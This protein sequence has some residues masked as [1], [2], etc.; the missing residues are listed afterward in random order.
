MQE[1]D[2]LAESECSLQLLGRVRSLQ[3]NSHFPLKEEEE[4]AT[5]YGHL[6]VSNA[7][8]AYPV[9]FCIDNRFVLISSVSFGT[10][11]TNCPVSGRQETFRGETSTSLEN[12][13]D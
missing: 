12:Y 6:P 8:C 5:C 4:M 7:P 9:G 3:A 2:G 13:L 10:V 11:I 1:E